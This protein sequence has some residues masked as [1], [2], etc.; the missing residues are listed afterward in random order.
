MET[1][2]LA[3]SSW[4]FPQMC[5]RDRGRSQRQRR[6]GRGV[7]F[8]QNSLPSITSLDPPSARAGSGAFTLTVN[9]SGFANGAH[10]R[11]GTHE[12]A[13]TFVNSTQLAAAVAAEDVSVGRVENCTVLN[14]G[15]GRELSNVVPFLIA[16]H[17]INLP[18]IRK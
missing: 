14:P 11:W 4:P 2:H 1:P 9:G 7:C 10:V 3:I 18:L 15:P 12:L 13:T 5:R 6:A 17:V 16:S 8:S